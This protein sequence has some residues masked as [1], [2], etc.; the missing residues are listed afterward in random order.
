MK[1]KTSLS[2]KTCMFGLYGWLKVKPGSSM[3]KVHISE[4]E[5]AFF[6]FEETFSENKCN[7]CMFEL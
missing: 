4:T 5:N 6:T 3:A 1:P 7:S 2:A